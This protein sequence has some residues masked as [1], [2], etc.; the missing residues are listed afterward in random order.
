MSRLAYDELL[1][2]A[3]LRSSR[4]S[5]T[6]FVLVAERTYPQTLP[7]ANDLSS[8]SQIIMIKPLQVQ[9]SNGF[10]EHLSFGWKGPQELAELAGH[11]EVGRHMTPN[12]ILLSS[13]PC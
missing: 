12:V 13:E 4:D 2:C 9:L 7:H 8:Q 10:W 11:G 1:A 6:C 5:S 3:R